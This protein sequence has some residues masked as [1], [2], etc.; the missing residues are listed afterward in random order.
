M[1]NIYKIVRNEKEILVIDFSN[2]NETKMIEL[3][4]KSRGLIILENKPQL[5]LGILNEKNYMTSNVLKHYKS[6]NLEALKLIKKQ[7]LIGVS[8][9]KRMIIK[10]YNFLFKRDVKVL[11]SKELAIEYLLADTKSIK[12]PFDN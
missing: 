12:G 4:S 7:A 2:L 10:G 3:I 11:E 5:V 8:E 9:P 6:D 1:E